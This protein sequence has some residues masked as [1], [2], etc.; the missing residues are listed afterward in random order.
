MNKTIKRI[1]LDTDIGVD[2]DD[3]VALAILLNMHRRAEIRI[4]CVTASS[5]REGATAAVSAIAS[6]YGVALQIGAMSL[7]ALECDAA[8]HYG[9]ALKEFYGTE[10]SK[11]DAVLLLR[12]ALAGQNEKVTIITIGPLSNM[13]RLLKSAPDDISELSGYELVREKVGEIYSMGGSFIQNYRFLK[14]DSDVFPEWNLLQDIA[15][16]RYFVE[17]CPV[18]I[19]FVPW[20]AGAYVLTRMG[21]NDNPVWYSMQK[22]AESENFPL[23]TEVFTRPSWDPVTCICATEGYHEYYDR[24]EGG[25]ITI[26][27]SGVTLFEN[28]EGGKHHIILLKEGYDK[29]AEKIN[30]SIEPGEKATALS[31]HKI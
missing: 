29:I 21:R 6:Y 5:T 15:A 26:E 31:E 13:E 4:E 25:K 14:M 27:E 12:K 17:N 1:I 3:A 23:E 18:E 20:E 11:N 19:T 8:N 2:C 9:K 10:D 7:P 24:S 16:A 30:H 28:I 22:Y